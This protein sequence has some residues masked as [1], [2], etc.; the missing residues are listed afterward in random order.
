MANATASKT[1]ASKLQA[2]LGISSKGKLATHWQN[3]AYDS[4]TD[5][6][7]RGFYSKEAFDA[8][9]QLALDTAAYGL[10]WS[11]TTGRIYGQLAMKIERNLNARQVCSL[12]AQIA[13][14]CKVSGDVPT[15]LLANQDQI[16]AMA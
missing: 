5:R 4:L 2:S 1:L 15:W 8:Q 13:Q 3:C 9:E 14:E 10:R 16:L 6:I 12:V 11:L 7:V